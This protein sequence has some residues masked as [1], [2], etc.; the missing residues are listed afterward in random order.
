MR[1]LA[2]LVAVCALAGCGGSSPASDYR[3]GGDRACARAAQATSELPRLVHDKRLTLDQAQERSQEI[4]RR[5]VAD[6]EALEPPSELKDAH[7]RLIALFGDRSPP[8]GDHDVIARQERLRAA[9]ASVGFKG[10]AS[11]ADAL[12]RVLREHR[13]D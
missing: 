8:T 4:G 7:S 13:G 9:Y 5:F 1:A 3:A 12:I 2:L 11:R 10:C 6:L